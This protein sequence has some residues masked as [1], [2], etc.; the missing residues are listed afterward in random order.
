MPNPRK[1]QLI[2]DILTHASKL[3]SKKDKIAF[4]KTWTGNSVLKNIIRMA[5]NEEVQFS[6]PEGAPPY[7][8]AETPRS[9]LYKQNHKIGY[10][11][12][13][14]TVQ[15]IKKEVIFV[16]MLEAMSPDESE[17]L[18]AVKDKTMPYDGLTWDIFNEAF[19]GVLT[20]KPKVKRKP[21]AKTKAK[22][23][24]VKAE[25][26][27]KPTKKQKTATKK[28]ARKPVDIDKGQTDADV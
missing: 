14:S 3:K 11:L 28:K 20:A 12:A 7:S 4:L 18:I 1:I 5:Y 26:K 27:P 19:P 2:P 9:N 24:E 17:L 25:P 8:P 22:V 10:F 6:V 16:K 15:Q 23:E 21:K 13:G